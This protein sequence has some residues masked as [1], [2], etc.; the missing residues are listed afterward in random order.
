MVARAWGGILAGRR[1][2]VKL[3]FV[4]VVVVVYTEFASEPGKPWRA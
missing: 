4:V 2:L 3:K 1:G